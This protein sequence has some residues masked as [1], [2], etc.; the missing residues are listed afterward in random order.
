MVDFDV[1]SE[2]TLQ[3]NCIAWALGNNS[4]WF[5]P[6][7]DYAYW[8]ECIPNDVT[9]DSIVELFRSEGFERCKDGS[10]EQGYEKIA[11]YALEYEV[12]H[13]ARQLVDGKWTSKLGKYEDIV[14]SSL[15]D[16]EGDGFHSY[17]RLTA[18]MIRPH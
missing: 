8:P 15:E 9:V 10:L 2:A 5:D 12:T 6:T 14:H 13:V 18:F 11:I 17:G 1:T 3:Y 7:L 4:S 16:L